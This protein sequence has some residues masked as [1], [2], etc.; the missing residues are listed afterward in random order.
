MHEA[1]EKGVFITTS[2]FSNGAKEYTSIIDS[3]VVLIDGERLEQ[4]IDYEH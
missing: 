3:K 4:L 2:D 1:S